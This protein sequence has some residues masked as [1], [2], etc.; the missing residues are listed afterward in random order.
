M[1]VPGKFN[2]VWKAILT[3]QKEVAFSFLAVNIFLSRAK[4][5]VKNNPDTLDKYVGEIWELFNKNAH[6]PSVQKDLA[7]IL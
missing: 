6:L 3:G 5:D 2:P 7:K 4:M 1:D